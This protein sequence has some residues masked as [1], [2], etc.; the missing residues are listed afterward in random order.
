[1]STL[2]GV[3]RLL[4]RPSECGALDQLLASVRAG[5][6]RVLVL[7]GEAGVGKTALLEYLVQRAS[8]DA[9]ARAT[10]VESEIELAFAG[11]HQLCA[12][13]VDRLDRLPGP[14]RD[15]LGTA[16]GLR[17]GDPPDRFLVGLAVLSLLSDV[18]E[19][20][21]LVCVVDDAQW[22]D[23]ASSHVLAFVARRLA[24]ESVGLVLAVRE[25]GGERP[26]EG[27]AE[28]VVGGLDAHDAQALLETVVTG[29]LDERVR[30]RLVSETR[31]N[32]L[33]LL[34][35]SRGRTP[36]ELAGGF[37]L[38]GGPALSSRIEE[39]FRERLA[40]LPPASRLLLLVAAAEPVG[41]PLLVWG[42]AARLGI[43]G[44][45]APPATSAGL[46]E[47]GAEVRFT[48]PLVRS[49]VYGA[50]DPEER[51]RVHR[52][53]AEAT[54]AAVD[55]DRRAWHRA[56]ATAGLDEDVA[57]ELERSAGRAQARGGLAAGAAFHE[58]AAGLTPD[59]VRRAQRALAAAQGKYQAGAPDAALRLL[60]TARAGPLDELGQ[61]RAQ[62]LDAHIT[63][64]AT[65]GSDAPPLL[66]EAA[67][68]L[69][70]L[71]ATLARATYLDAFAAALSADRLVRGGDPREVAAAVLAADWE[72][73]VSACD[74][75]LDGLALLMTEGYA[76]GAP[77]LKQALRAFREEPMA[78]EDELRWLW[79]ACHIARALGDD[80]AWDEL[81]ARQVALAR[82]SGALSLL[83]VALDEQVHA[84]LFCGR[85]AAARSHAA[86]AYAVLEATGS[87]LS[88]RGGIALAIFRGDETEALALIEARR[89][90]VLRRGE[91]FWLASTDWGAAVLYNG[92]GRYD[93]A[94]A[95]AERA[96]ADPH[97]LGT[98]MWLLADLV[99]A[100]VHSGKP[101]RA[102]GPSALL[103]EIAEANGTDWAL[104][105]DARSRAMLGDGDAA[106]RLYREAIERLGRTRIR[107]ALGRSQLV[108]GEWLRREGRRVDAREQLR[109]AHAT[110]LEAGME[111][112]AERARRELLAT[113]ETVRK[114]T[115]ETLDDLT[116]QE[117]QI[118]RLAATG[119][120]NPEIGAQLFLSPRTVEWH[121]RKVFGKLGITS[122]RQ[123]RT[124]LHDGR[125]L[126]AAPV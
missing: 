41:D 121:L 40:P 54:D 114:R 3:P 53:L 99:E 7:R 110:L 108:Y 23:G 96:A 20:R 21:P 55:P 112:F 126:A 22:L 90:D 105:L 81:I 12:P 77:A 62:L 56:Q 13:F 95:A 80:A 51:Q 106:E 4:G 67:K 63:F 45:A 94:L 118:A 15:A 75:L 88:L 34:E 37:G 104:G 82:R 83:P 64:A 57:A 97:G 18:A 1:M 74:F 49:A 61:A 91:G 35:L 79:L 101:E 46:I 107:V 31:G 29:P 117:H 5:Q 72:P 59:P 125:G 28:L 113:G 16:L 93:D 87:H 98:P 8:G 111:A 100:A 109:P 123:L 65:R 30:D 48:H 85:L 84:D 71:D 89:Q 103:A 32:P 27:V 69:E 92:L 73:C 50:A 66:L 11:L 38:D 115:V 119:H 60:A 120:T 39:R 6:S 24:A 122:R 19:E 68:R 9:I 43:S 26:F 58:R 33:A 86:E 2:D 17:E 14:Q 10:G 52:A 42:A 102:A 44:D 47:F 70:P 36:A 116:P 78:E 25:S 76:A 124:T